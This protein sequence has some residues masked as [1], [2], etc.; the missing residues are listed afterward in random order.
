MSGMKNIIKKWD[1]SERLARINPTL[2]SFLQLQPIVFP[3]P[4]NLLLCTPHLSPQIHSPGLLQHIPFPVVNQ[5][6]FLMNSRS[7]PATAPGN[8]DRKS[9]R[10]N[11]SH[12]SI[13]YDVICMKKQLKNA[14]N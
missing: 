10:L 5:Q 3:N 12:V 11:S 1:S 8:G 4:V 9:T 14:Y 6:M 7:E 13:S 2:L